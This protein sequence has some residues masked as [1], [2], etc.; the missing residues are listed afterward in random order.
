GA[1]LR[2]SADRAIFEAGR[3]TTFL[4]DSGAAASPATAP[5]R[6]RPAQRVTY[7]E[8]FDRAVARIKKAEGAIDGGAD[9]SLRNLTAAQ[10]YEEMTA[11][12]VHNITDFT[13]LN[14][15]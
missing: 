4:R 2:A 9:P 8:L 10:L 6:V 1:A 12:Q 3:M 5:T 11:Q 7:R 13:R 15:Q 14:R